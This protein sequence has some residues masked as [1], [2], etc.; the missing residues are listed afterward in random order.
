VADTSATNPGTTSTQTSTTPTNSA[1]MVARDLAKAALQAALVPPVV[2]IDSSATYNTSTTQSQVGLGFSST[3][4]TF[5][6]NLGEKV[7]DTSLLTTIQSRNVYFSAYHLK[8]LTRLYAFFDNVNVSEYVDSAYRI[9]LNKVV[10]TNRSKTF[11]RTN[12]NVEVLFAKGTTIYVNQTPII[13][14]NANGYLEATNTFSWDGITYT[15]V[16]A[17]KSTTLTTDENGYIAGTF[18]IPSKKFNTG[19]RPF[20]LCDSSTNNGVEITT[21]AEFMYYASGMSVSKQ[22]QT[23]STRINQVTINPMLKS[24]TTEVAG[25]SIAPQAVSAVNPVVITVDQTAPYIINYSPSKGATGVSISSNIVFTFDDTVVANAGTVTLT[26][27]NGTV[28]PSTAVLS[29]GNTL[30]VT[31][32][33]TLDKSTVY[34]VNIPTDYVRDST[35]NKFPGSTDYQI[36]TELPVVIPKPIYNSTVVNTTIYEG[37]QASV[38]FKMTNVAVGTKLYYSVVPV[39]S[40]L[41]TSDFASTSNSYSGFFIVDSTYQNTVRL[42]TTSSDGTE[43]PEKFNIQLYET[44]GSAAVHSTETITILD[45]PISPYVTTTF[46]AYS[47]MEGNSTTGTISSNLLNTELYWKII[48]VFGIDS[49]DFI[50]I[51]MNGSVITNNLGTATLPTFFVNKDS[52]IEDVEKFAVEIYSDANQTNL[53]HTSPN[54]NVIDYKKTFDSLEVQASI[55]DWV[56]T[57]FSNNT[58]NEG[59]STQIYIRSNLPNTKLYGKFIDVS[60][61]GITST[62]LGGYLIQG[63]DGS[64][65]VTFSI[66]TD[67]NGNFDSSISMSSDGVVENTEKFAINFYKDSLTGTLLHTSG[68]VIIYDSNSIPPTATVVTNFTS[69]TLTEGQSTTCTLTSNLLSTTLYWSVI[70]T[71]TGGVNSADFLSGTLTGTITTNS[72]GSA[73]LPIFTTNPDVLIE[74]TEKFSINFFTGSL[75]GTLVHTS[76]SVAIFDTATTPPDFVNSG[77]S[78]YTLTEGQS[79]TCSLNTNLKNTTLYWTVVDIG[80]SG[81][82]AADFLSGSLTGTVLTDSSGGAILPIFNTNTDTNVEGTEQ[83][84]VEIRKNSTSGTLLH[85]TSTVSVYNAAVPSAAA[86]FVNSGFSSYILTEGQSTT[87][88]LTS[89]QYNST[90][91]WTVVDISASGTNATDFLSGSLTGTVVTDSSG[92][93]TLPIFT[94]NTD[95]T[96]E[97]TE[98]WAIEIRKTSLSG[99][100]LHTTS[101]VSVY[102][103]AVPLAPD[104]VNSGFSSYTLTEGQSTTCTLTSNLLSTTL[105]WKVVDISA[106][107]TNA[108]DFLSGSLTGTVTTNSSGG[109]ILPTFTTNTDATVETTEQWA[110]EI[111]KTSLSGTLL[112]TTSTISVLDGV[113]AVPDFINSSFNS[114]TLTEGQSTTCTLTS[115]MLS[116][117]LYWKVVDKGTGGTNATDFLSG[118]LTGTVTT[119]SSGS[120]TLP[121]FTTNSD[122]TVEGTEKFAIEIYKTS[123]SGTLLHTTTNISVLEGVTAVPDFVNSGF[124]SYTLTEGQSTTCTLTSN[125]LSTTLYWKVVDKGTGG[126]NA[127]DFLSGSLTGT[128]TTNA[129]GNASLPVFTTNTDATVE[130]TEKFAIEIYKTSLSGTLLH[131]TTNISVLDGVTVVPDFVNSGFSSYTLTEGQSTTCTLTSNLLS[132]TLYWKVVDKGTGGTNATDFLSGS[133]TGTV[134]TNSS[135]GAII[136]PPFT[137]NTDATIEGTELWAIE[138]Y[139]TSLSGTLLHTTATVSLYD[140]SVVDSVSSSFT[141]PVLTE[142]QSTTCTLTSNMLSTTLYWKV[143]D[144]GTGGTN[145]TDFLSGSLTGTVTTNALGNASLPVFTTNSDATIEGTEL[146]AIE[147]YKTSLSGTLLHTTASVTVRDNSVVDYV[148]SSFTSP[149]LTEGQTTT[150][151]LASNLLSTTLYWKVVDKGTGGTNATDFL[152]GSISGSVTTNALGTVDLPTFT[153]NIDATIEGTELWAIDIYK[154]SLSGTLLHTTASVTTY[155]TKVEAAV[156]PMPEYIL[157]ASKAVV[158][159]IYIDVKL[160]TKNIVIG[161]KIYWSIVGVG[162]SATSDLDFVQTSGVVTVTGSDILFTVETFKDKLIEPDESCQLK[163]YSTSN[164][165][166]NECLGSSNNITIVDSPVPTYRIEADKSE[167]IEGDIVTFTV[168]T[169]NVSDTTPLYYNLNGINITSGDFG[170]TVNFEGGNSGTIPNRTSGVCTFTKQVAINA[171]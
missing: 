78:S 40:T 171:D 108:T 105:Y 19:T 141:S 9:V 63:T 120:G 128:V 101:T 76:S 23:L 6:T 102:N 95:A 46:S 58:V 170:A 100:L 118:S 119:N 10:H 158:E 104:F 91:Y 37:A 77:F 38:I 84:A 50:D 60:T 113:T 1:D 143:V 31:P 151:T 168:T 136:S 152:S 166:P 154:T 25:T 35:G 144:K 146:W 48:N 145:A 169:T 41:N 153:T 160:T 74:G 7:V 39:S 126:T 148:A 79:T 21:S 75:S 88:T 45:L 106:S 71:S 68:S 130:G 66:T 26:K 53:V 86:D 13:S 107:G 162:T 69:N 16:S 129:L 65:H 142:G 99:T 121:I 14:T 137:T 44:L 64:G 85:T 82:N 47:I 124:S 3:Q 30:T 111:R 125:M 139:K 134:T 138:I 159:G 12:S 103:A 90:L 57:T 115:N 83:W 109:A 55:P 133:L 8:P 131:T 17:S 122:T 167:F 117:T 15:V 62:D 2:T 42:D 94:T 135:G 163:I 165:L 4:S 87:C 72:S 161:Q 22:S 34:Q 5:N 27:S 114:Y 155:E 93:G 147:I 127:T 43:S 36:T 89:N 164:K 80:A 140:N 52:T 56:S 18:M 96:V 20:L 61:G 29:G 123:L 150:C 116:T 33:K 92:S 112:H 24:S 73:T 70:D 81:T 132:T 49:V 54:L 28:I 97:T 98:Q 32:T 11:S 157:T 67:S 149:V 156:P 51:P 59:A 110:I